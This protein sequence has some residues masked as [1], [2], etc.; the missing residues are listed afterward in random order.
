[1][2]LAPLPT[3][4]M[5]ISRILTPL[6]DSKIFNADFLIV[7]RV[8]NRSYFNFK[9]ADQNYTEKSQKIS[10][11]ILKHSWC[12]GGDLNSRPP[13]YETSALNQLS[14]P[15]I[16]ARNYRQKALNFL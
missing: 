16:K 1:M 14:Y 5:I 13:A 8:C 6:F 12:Q 2:L 4:K 11:S 3:P 7:Q 10:R 15:D 9:Y